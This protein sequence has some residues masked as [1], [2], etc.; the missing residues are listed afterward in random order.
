M[1]GLSSY[2]DKTTQDLLE[3]QNEFQLDLYM[4]DLDLQGL[5]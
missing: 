3:D 5:N 2:L 4:T 1:D